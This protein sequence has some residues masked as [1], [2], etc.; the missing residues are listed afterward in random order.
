[1]DAEISMK[2]LRILRYG[3]NIF[4]LLQEVRRELVKWGGKK[5]KKKERNSKMFPYINRK[6]NQDRVLNGS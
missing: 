2:S 5:K 1:M 4:S 3:H 6:Q